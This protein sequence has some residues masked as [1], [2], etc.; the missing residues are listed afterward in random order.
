MMNNFKRHRNNIAEQLTNFRNQT[1]SPI[2]SI[3]GENNQSERNI[4]NYKWFAD[5][6][7]NFYE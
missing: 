7:G 6:T 2:K 5:F 3:A 4:E 1:L